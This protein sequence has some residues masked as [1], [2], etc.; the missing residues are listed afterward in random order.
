[1]LL[2]LDWAGYFFSQI[3]DIRQIFNAGYP[4]SDR[5]SCQRQIS[6][7]YQDILPDIGNINQPDIRYPD[8]FNIRSPA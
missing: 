6:G 3:P 7:K 4:K 5:I 1:M 8:S 2:K